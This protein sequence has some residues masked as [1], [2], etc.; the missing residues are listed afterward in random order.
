M[1][2]LVAMQSFLA[3][4][5]GGSFTKAAE[6][7]RV[8]KGRITQLVGALEQHL[9]VQLLIRTTRKM[10]VTNEGR[11]FAEH[12]RRV[13]TEVEEAETSVG[14]RRSHLRGRVR[15]DVPSAVAA[16][17]LIPRLSSFHA[18]HPSILVEIGVTDRVI[19]VFREGVDCVIR[20]GDISGAGMRFRRIGDLAAIACASPGY[21]ARYGEPSHP[22]ELRGPTHHAVGFFSATSNRLWPF[23][24]RR[25][26]TAIAVEARC[27]VAV[28]DAIANLAAGVAGM[29]VILIPAVLAADELARGRLVPVLSDWEYDPLPL[30]VGYPESRRLPTRVRVFIDWLMGLVRLPPAGGVG[31]K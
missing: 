16:S 7:L 25:E 9:G 30:Y 26:G 15:V 13:L 12:A 24:A 23:R 28:N 17:L 4:V 27:S 22:D 18:T 1:D 3:V 20:A 29:G 11:L 14:A 6:S 19:D 10:A 5:D 8:T 21:V 2:R 31:T